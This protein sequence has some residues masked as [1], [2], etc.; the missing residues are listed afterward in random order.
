MQKDEEDRKA[1]AAMRNSDASRE[2]EAQ[3]TRQAD[4]DVLARAMEARAAARG[5][6]CARFGDVGVGAHV[7]CGRDCGVY[8]VGTH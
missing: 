5:C 7:S 3:R 8:N 2:K 6:V 1:E 4:S